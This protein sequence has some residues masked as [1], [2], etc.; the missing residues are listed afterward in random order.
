MM[1]IVKTID[2]KTKNADTIKAIGYQAKCIYQVRFKDKS[3]KQDTTFI[4][5][6]INKDIV[7]REE[8]LN[9]PYKVDLDK[10]N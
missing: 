4:I 10:L 8:F 6:N 5:L 2:S 7:K 3:V 1:S 9:L